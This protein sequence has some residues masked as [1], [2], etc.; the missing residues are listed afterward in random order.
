MLTIQGTPFLTASC[1][2]IYH[3][4]NIYSF[5]LSKKNDQEARNID[6]FFSKKQEKE[7]ELEEL[8][9]ELEYKRRAVEEVVGSMEEGVLEHYQALSMENDKIKKVLTYLPRLYITGFLNQQD[10]AEQQGV[11]ES[12]VNKVDHLKEEISQSP[13]KQEV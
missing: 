13:L 11:L 1:G 8:K 4:L 5:Q 3:A 2:I 7:K 6:D 12:L 10:L 9:V